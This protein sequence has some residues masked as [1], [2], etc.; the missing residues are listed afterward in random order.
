MPAPFA[1]YVIRERTIIKEVKR[2][3]EKGTRMGRG[4]ER[5]MPSFCLREETSLKERG[6]EVVDRRERRTHVK[7]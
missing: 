1:L 3:G 4:A 2:K 7:E 5:T 6:P